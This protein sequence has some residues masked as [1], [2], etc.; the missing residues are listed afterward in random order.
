M[1]GTS[2]DE[3]SHSS[4]YS[5]LLKTDEGP[6]SSNEGRNEKF[7]YDS[8]KDA[9]EMQWEKTPKIPA[10]RPNPHWLDNINVTNELVYRYQVNSRTLSD[11]LNDDLFALKNIHQVRKVAFCEI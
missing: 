1:T 5:S 11:V 10:K 8:G 7:K 9:E 3:S 6:T 2:E 4:F